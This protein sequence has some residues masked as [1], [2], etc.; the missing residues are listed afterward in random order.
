[1]RASRQRE[2]LAPIRSILIIRQN[3]FYK[4]RVRNLSSNSKFFHFHF[5]FEMSSKKPYTLHQPPRFWPAEWLRGWSGWVTKCRP[6]SCHS[7][8]RIRK[9][10]GIN[11][12]NGVSIIHLFLCPFHWSLASV[13]LQFH[14]KSF[15]TPFC[16][17][18]SISLSQLRKSV[19]FNKLPP[20]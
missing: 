6:K 10:P 13:F 16:F 20:N 3:F 19:H 8:Q 4:Y 12:A 17:S 11:R 14:A 2:T 1:M 18:H 9:G 15:W 7:Y 5:T